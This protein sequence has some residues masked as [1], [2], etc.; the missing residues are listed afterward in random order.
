[1]QDVVFVVVSFIVCVAT[2]AL[3]GGNAAVFNVMN[4]GAIGDG[5]HDDSKVTNSNYIYI[6]FILYVKYDHI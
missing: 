4:Y 6:P 2:F 5:K 1:M 3:E